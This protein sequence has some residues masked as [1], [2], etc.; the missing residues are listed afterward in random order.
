VRVA[1]GEKGVG[2]RTLRSTP[3]WG[4]T[5]ASRQ[6]EGSARM[7]ILPLPRWISKFCESW[8]LQG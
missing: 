5:P 4:S 8:P 6:N 7:R 3:L 1:Q 2:G